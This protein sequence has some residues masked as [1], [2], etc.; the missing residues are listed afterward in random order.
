MSAPDPFTPAV[1]IADLLRRSHPARL[2][3]LRQLTKEQRAAVGALL[4]DA[5]VAQVMR[6]AEQAL[7]L[8]RPSR[9]EQTGDTDVPT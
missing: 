3:R 8:E 7:A 9:A 6:D 2:R 5:L 1:F 4:I